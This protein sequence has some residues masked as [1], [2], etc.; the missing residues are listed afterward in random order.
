MTVPGRARMVR[1]RTGGGYY[2][3][4]TPTPGTADTARVAYRSRWVHLA[5]GYP[6]VRFLDDLQEYRQRT[7]D[8]RRVVNA[9]EPHDHVYETLL[10]NGGDVVLRGSGIVGSRILQRLLDDVEERGADTRI[11][12]LFRTFRTTSEGPPT[13]RRETADGFNYQAFNYPKA[14]WGG[15]LRERLLAAE[16]EE[17][18]ELI[19]A[20]G[21][22]NTP[23]RAQWDDQ[24]DR[25]RASGRYRAAVGEVDAVVTADDGRIRTDIVDRDGRRSSIDADFIID[26]TGL[27]GEIESSQI[28]DDLLTHTGAGKNPMGRLDVSPDFEVLGTRSDP[29]RLYASGSITLGGPYAGVDSFLGLQYVALQITDDLAAQ[30]MVPRLSPVRSIAQWFRWARGAAP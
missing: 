26:A 18:A 29:G 14:A 23:R 16:G 15:T 7:G 1:R 10:G 6:G 28:L 9:Y 30:G 24:L 4:L 8:F 13:F 22:T 19:K 2:T 17:R 21:G 12:H 11:W 3:I 25:A 27:E 20:M 5:V